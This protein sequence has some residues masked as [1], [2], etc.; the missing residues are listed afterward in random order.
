ML[1]R[2]EYLASLPKKRMAAGVLIRDAQGRVLIVKPIYRADWLI[3]GGHIEAD[4]SPR[5]AAIR[6][7]RE[8]IGLDI[9]AAR[10][11]LVDY[12]HAHGDTTESMQFIFDGGML[13]TEQMAQIA[14]PA[15][16]LSEWRMVALDIAIQLLAPKLAQ[17]VQWAYAHGDQLTY[18]EDGVPV[19]AQ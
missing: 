6:E 5:T 11:L 14:L 2:A 10:L 17:R 15:D 13:T 19:T 9:A 7:A 16:E 4:E 3:P 18:M 1:P 12:Q 8:E